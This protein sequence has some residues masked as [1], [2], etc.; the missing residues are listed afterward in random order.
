MYGD[1]PRRRRLRAA[2]VVAATTLLALAVPAGAPLYAEVY[3]GPDANTVDEA[4]GNANL[5]SGFDSPVITQFETATFSA[6]IIYGT[7][8]DPNLPTVKIAWSNEAALAA[9]SEGT[10]EIEP[11]SASRQFLDGGT[12]RSDGGHEI[13]WT[14]NVTP[15]VDGRQTLI[16]SILPAVVVEGVPLLGLADINEPIAVEVDVHPVKH[17]FDEVVTAAAAMET[18]VPGQMTVG[19]EYDISASMSLAGHTDTVSADIELTP[20]EDSAAVTIVK[21]S[22]AGPATRLTQAASDENLVRRWTVIPDEP[23]QVA[24]VFTATVE[25]EAAA[26]GLQQDVVIQE[27]ARATGAGPSFWDVLQKPVLYL[28]PFA[29]LALTALG[30]WAGWKK[31][32]SKED[33]SDGGDA[34]G[35]GEPAS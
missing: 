29:G 5:E 14:W 2:I 20:S 28:A 12:R 34:E 33:G 32:K 9:Q 3:P 23:G 25:G 16:L 8:T 31:L 4:L 17:D 22:A 10:F 6:T 24:L 11:T 27:S 7:T 1:A 21:A 35:S 30:V 18:D 15:L 26:H 19:E 13:T